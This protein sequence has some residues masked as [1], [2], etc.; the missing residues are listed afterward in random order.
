MKIRPEN[1][2]ATYSIVAKDPD[3]GEF[4]VAVQTHQMTVGNFVP[5]L[6]A[7][8]GALATQALG[9]IRFGPMGLALLRQGIPAVRVVDGLVATD[10]EAIHRQLALVDSEGRVAAWTGEG[11]IEHAAHYTGDGY[12]VQA[13]MM[14]KA[15][16]VDAMAGAYEGA[17]GDLAIRMMKALEAAQVEEGDIRGMQSAALKVVPGEPPTFSDPAEWRPRYDLRVDEHEDPISELSRLVR[18]RRAQLVDQDGHRALDEGDKQAALTHWAEA[19][20]LAP[21]LEELTYW[22]GLTLADEPGDVDDAVDILRPMLVEDPRREHWL[23]LIGRVDRAGLFERQDT[24]QDLM[25]ALSDLA[26]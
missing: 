18:L 17:A 11:C 19:R 21:E 20:T 7:G 24:A 12:A 16:V 4:G 5:W 1:N 3:S 26:E 8:V 14:T 9:N 10:E 23:D 15:T 25:E 13:N 6:E 22:Q 2:Y